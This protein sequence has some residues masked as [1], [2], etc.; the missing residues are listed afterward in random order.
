MARYDHL[1]IWKDAVTLAGVLEEAVR[2]FPRY[3]KYALGADLRRQAYA[4]CRGVVVANGLFAA[5]ACPELDEVAAPTKSASTG[6]GVVGASAPKGFVHSFAALVPFR[7]EAASARFASVGGASAP[8]THSQPHR[9]PMGVLSD[10]FHQPRAQRIGDDITGDGCQVFLPA[11]PMVMETGLPD[12]RAGGSALTVDGRTAK[13]FE[14]FNEDGKRPVPQ[15]DQPVKMVGHEDIGQS[16]ANAGLVASAQ[17]VHGEA[18]QG[19][20]GEETRAFV[21]YRGDEINSPRFGDPALAQVGGM[22]AGQ[23]D[24]GVYRA[25]AVVGGTFVGAASAANEPPNLFGAEAPLTKATPVGAALAAN[26]G[27]NSFGA[28]APPTT[29]SVGAASAAKEC[30]NECTKPFGAEAPPTKANPV[31]AASSAKKSAN[32]QPYPAAPKTKKEPS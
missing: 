4:V 10:T 30:E 19:E 28:E 2:R 7:V 26:K 3:H 22:E 1:P 14:T 11:H 6:R 12:L 5:E 31:G 8:K 17:F 27:P 24:G 18:S 29:P 13:G 9:I 23:H 20:I 21:A 32:I 25:A 15:L 16:P